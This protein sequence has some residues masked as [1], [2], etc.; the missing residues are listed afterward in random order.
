MTGEMQ[1]AV[2]FVACCLKALF[3][4]R[5]WRKLPGVP[6]VSVPNFRREPYDG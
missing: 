4:V 5:V 1:A 3:L 2:L 6:K